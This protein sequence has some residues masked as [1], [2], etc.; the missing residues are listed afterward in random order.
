MSLIE[1]RYH[2]KRSTYSDIFEHLPTLYK[3]A[4]ECS[5]V[6]E[7]GTREHVGT[8]SFLLGKPKKYVGVD[9]YV[10][11]HLPE[12]EQAAKEEGIDFK[13][14][15][16]CTLAPDFVIEDTEFLFIDTAHTY[17]QLKQ[18]LARHAHKVSK[19]IGFHD[20][21]T[22]GYVNEPPYEANAHIEAAVPPDAP[23][24]L[25]PAIEEFIAAN[26]QWQVHE[27]YQNNN[28]LTILKKVA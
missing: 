10:S 18:E 23:K 20:T 12:V 26:P 14:I 19:Y 7:M 17:A 28:G 6:T 25:I 24:G 9:F 8:W 4:S 16:T 15:Q 5:H 22:N 3:Y 2:E 21:V 13:F 27:H 11:P 1:Q